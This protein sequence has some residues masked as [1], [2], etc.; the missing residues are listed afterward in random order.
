MPQITVDTGMNTKPVLNGIKDMNSAIQSLRGIVSQVGRSMD[1]SVVGFAKAMSNNEAASREA[2]AKIQELDRAYADLREKMDDIAA[3]KFM[4]SEY[5]QLNKDLQ[6]QEKY[7]NRLN[8]ARKKDN[9]EISNTQIE[10]QAIRDAMERLKSEGKAFILGSETEEFQRLGKQANATVAAAN[11]LREQADQKLAPI[12]LQQW[13]EMTTVTGTIANGLARVANAAMFAGNALI[14]PFEALNRLIPMVLSGLASLAKRALDAA[15]SFAKMVG[16]RILSTLQG[17][18]SSALRAAVGLARMAASGVV[19]F[20]QRMASA[21]KNAAIHLA[22][23]AGSAVR[24]GLKSVGSLAANAAKAILGIGKNSNKANG[25]LKQ[26]LTMLIRYGLG[27]RSIFMLVRRLRSAVVEAFKNMA[28]QVPEVNKAISAMASSFDRMKNS[29]ATAF[30]PILN[31]VAPFLASLMDMVSEALTRVGMFFAALT[32]QD[33][34]YKATKA[35]ID[36]AKSLDK[37][38]K[39]AKE[40][41][42]QLASFDELNILKAPN[43]N[44]SGS[45]A[46]TDTPTSE[47]VK[48][49]LESGIRN[50]ANTI[51]EMLKNG[52]FDDLGQLL[53]SKVNDLVAS[54]DWSGYATKIGNLANSV[55]KLYN[56]FMDNVHWQNIGNAIASAVNSLLDSVNWTE[57]GRAFAQRINAIFGIL[58]GLVEDVNWEQLGMSLAQAVWGFFGSIDWVGIGNTVGAGIT[59]ISTSISDFAENFPW[60]SLGTKLAE[61]ANTL[62]SKVSPYAVAGALIKVIWSAFTLLK[63]FIK[64]FNWEEHGQALQEGIKKFITDLPVELIGETLNEAIKSIL[65]Y[66]MPALQ[67]EETWALA[68]EKFATLVTRLFGNDGTEDNIWSRLSDAIVLLVKDVIASLKGF[69][70]NFKWGETGIKFHDAVLKLIENFPAEELG[71]L[72][73]ISLQGII[74]SFGPTLQDPKTWREV[75]VKL[76]DALNQL[77]GKK[78]LWEDAG[79]TANGMLNGILT[80]GQ[81]F[82]DNFQADQAAINIKTALGKI[83]WG[84]IASNTWEL[85]RTALAKAGNF[86]DALF[87]K[88][89]DYTQIQNRGD[90]FYGKQIEE[91]MAFNNQRIGAKIGARLR[92][93][94]SKIPWQTIISEMWQAVKKAGLNIEDF[95]ASLFAVTDDDIKTAGGNK[96][97]AIG[98][99][100]G[101]TISAAFGK[102]NW[103][104]FGTD[105]GIGVGNLFAAISTCFQTI[106]DD[107]TLKTSVDEFFGAIPDDIAESA[108]N[109]ANEFLKKLGKALINRLWENIKQDLRDLGRLFVPE[110]NDPRSSKTIFGEESA[111]EKETRYKAMGGGVL[112]KSVYTEFADLGGDMSDAVADGY[113]DQTNARKQDIQQTVEGVYLPSQEELLPKASQTGEALV[114][115]LTAAFST[116]DASVYGGATVDDYFRAF[117]ARFTE[118]DTVKEDFVAAVDEILGSGAS[119]A[120]N[121]GK[122]TPELFWYA[123]QNHMQEQQGGVKDAF[124]ETVSDTVDV[125]EVSTQAGTDAF[126]SFNSAYIQAVVDQQGD[127]KEATLQAFDQIWTAIDAE[128]NGNILAF[129]Y[130]S[131]FIGTVEDEEGNVK[132]QF[133]DVIDRCFGSVDAYNEAK[134]DGKDFMYGIV[135]GMSG[136][137]DDTKKK[138][139]GVI[140]NVLDY[141]KTSPDGFDEHSPSKR[142]AQYGQDFMSGF[143]GGV[144]DNEK[145]TKDNTVGVFD[146]IFAGIVASA[147][148]L[149]FLNLAVTASM[150]SMSKTISDTLDT[151]SDKFTTGW[152][153]VTMATT[154]QMALMWSAVLK[155]IN[156]ITTTVPSR[157]NTMADAISSR[158]WW[159]VGKNIVTGIKGGINDNWAWLENVVWNLAIR[160]YNTA[161]NAL[162]IHSPSTLFRDGV[163]AMLGL[164]VAEGFEETQPTILNAVTDVAD[165]MAEKMTSSDIQIGIDTDYALANFSDKITDSFTT[166]LDRLQAIADS[167]TF[168]TPDVAAGTVLPYNVTAKVEN[169]PESLV[170]A[171]EVSNEDL[172]SVII[173]ATNNAALSIVEAIQRGGN[174]GPDDLTAQTNKIIEE[175]NR[176]TRAQGASPIMV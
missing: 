130:M 111:E 6:D 158:N 17:L 66:I 144:E 76:S 68:G 46:S 161:R 127:A 39:S 73:T 24:T 3:E 94:L 41:E 174:N 5:A 55:I 82:L 19:S 57:L 84:E 71:H 38:S 143:S 81:G 113:I 176:R 75:G 86:V 133:K 67:D 2:H 40:A 170:E 157:F 59:N 155:V 63:T 131:A 23:M 37:T 61:G 47:F 105:L 69:V 43:E 163:G 22:Q 4:T 58:A 64:V 85:L 12:Y 137:E 172:A 36:Y 92:E 45:S 166:L 9:A 175:I 103:E 165:A 115:E 91:I 126:D 60:E 142:A 33:Y 52:E 110:L 35:T 106:R 100:V 88:Q 125:S 118:N 44:S 124:A 89:A 31:A 101:K 148:A 34:V 79:K 135:N 83:K 53:A 42:R 121:Q 154:T 129:Q 30:Q 136:E 21:A 112:P 7:L 173:Q 11:K 93:A 48:T 28:K 70:E 132:P 62:F 26:T 97:I 87:D 138:L 80:F 16:S 159:N 1:A 114:A 20:I 14:H 104:Q 51:K 153:D 56:A 25:G 8:A 141:L 29:M 10:I 140:D 90:S 49:P 128:G 32:G 122:M 108:V 102:I 169:S 95:L 72:L 152:T 27:I 74:D 107:G 164:G 171:L 150:N 54:I 146:K 78:K 77:F 160:L 139:E 96:L 134:A 145:D 123:W 13:R 99:K 117:E 168:R 65:D 147:G 15:V 119:E 18:A 120:Y 116:I 149:V 151:I 109:A 50:F 156:T 167:V 162:G 98:A